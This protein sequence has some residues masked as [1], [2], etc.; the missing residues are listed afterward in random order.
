MAAIQPPSV[1][2]RIIT[3]IADDATED[4][5]RVRAYLDQLGIGA[6]PEHPEPWLA[7]FLTHIAAALR[8]RD[9]ERKGYSFHREAGLPDGR[10]AIRDAVRSLRDPDVNSRELGIAVMSLSLKHFAW[11]GRRDLGAD[12][13][14]D[15]P[16]EEGLLESIADFLWAHRPR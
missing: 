12:V 8:L 1:V 11:S 16:D 6:V 9:W 15:Q 7:R 3:A 13:A 2:T 10:Q 4:A 5:I 14:L